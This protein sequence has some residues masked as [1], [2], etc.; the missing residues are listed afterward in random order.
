MAGGSGAGDEFGDQCAAE[1]AT[2]SFVMDVHAKLGGAAVGGARSK[3][4]KRGPTDDRA[5]LF[6]D[7]DRVGGGAILEPVETL[8]QRL[9]LED[10]R[11]R[12]VLDVVVEDGVDGRCVGVR[13]GTEGV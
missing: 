12:G 13:G 1:P 3:G 10:K 6:R 5:A 2:V 11:G 7:D 9:W 4:G 8:L